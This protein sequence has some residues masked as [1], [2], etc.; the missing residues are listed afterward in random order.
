MKFII[1][2][3]YYLFKNLK[4]FGPNLFLNLKVL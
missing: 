2:E 4:N 3:I 1:Q